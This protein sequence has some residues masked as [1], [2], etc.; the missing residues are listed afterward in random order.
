[1]ELHTDTESLQGFIIRRL[2]E[3]SK[4][5]R[6]LVSQVD[7]KQAHLNNWLRGKTL[8]SQKWI[9]NRASKFAAALNCEESEI[10]R[11]IESSL[12]QQTIRGP[13]PLNKNI[14]KALA[15]DESPTDELLDM[16][17]RVQDEVGAQLTYE[18]CKDLI[19][20]KKQAT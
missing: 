3:L 17:K 12:H 11:R 8:V 7:A 6:W 2:K 20:L 14:L 18:L 10:L 13:V 9:A 5:Q 4:S 1:M 16:M 15:E 19:K